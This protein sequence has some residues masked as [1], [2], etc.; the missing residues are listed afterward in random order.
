MKAAAS[1]TSANKPF[2][3]APMH[4]SIALSVKRLVSVSGFRV[5]S[6][7][8]I[9]VPWVSKYNKYVKGRPRGTALAPGGSASEWFGSG[10]DL[11][12]K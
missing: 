5:G 3:P 9:V 1:F 8:R 7:S 2:P 6:I 10:P 4:N 12:E 11:P